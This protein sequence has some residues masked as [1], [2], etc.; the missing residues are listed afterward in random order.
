MGFSRFGFGSGRPEMWRCLNFNF[1]RVG[2]TGIGL[3]PLLNSVRVDLRCGD[4]VTSTF[5]A[6]EERALGFS[7]C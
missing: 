1:W 5:G 6:W 4:A 3:Q 7:R 2:G